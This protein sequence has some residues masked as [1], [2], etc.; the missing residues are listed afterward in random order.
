[1]HIN[2]ITKYYFINKFE[3]KNIDNQDRQTTVIYRNYSSKS[4]DEKLILRIKKY[5]KK[6]ISNFIYLMI[7]SLQIN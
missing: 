1:M 6:K 4:T 2:M 5:C 3:T 7:L